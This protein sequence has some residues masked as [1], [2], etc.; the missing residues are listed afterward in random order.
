MLP[1]SFTPHSIWSDEK[2][3]SLITI[4]SFYRDFVTLTELVFSLA[5]LIFEVLY[6]LKELQVKGF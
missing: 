4:L 1:P 6:L 2:F 5:V 3:G